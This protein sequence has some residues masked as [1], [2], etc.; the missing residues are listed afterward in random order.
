MDTL[1][2]V[3][4]QMPSL[5]L[6]VD[7]NIRNGG[8]PK[9]E[10]WPPSSDSFDEVLLP[11]EGT[12]QREITNIHPAVSFATGRSNKQWYA[13]LN[14]GA[15]FGYGAFGYGR[16]ALNDSVFEKPHAS[17]HTCVRLQVGDVLEVRVPGRTLAFHDEPWARVGWRAVMVERPTASSKPSGP[18]LN[19]SLGADE[20]FQ[21]AG[22][23]SLPASMYAL[24]PTTACSTETETAHGISTTRC[25]DAKGA[26]V[27]RRCWL[28][29]NRDG[30]PASKM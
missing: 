24:V 21:V 2:K 13:Q 6:R 4:S 5:S 3:D 30:A 22:Q 8:L 12:E 18:A 28:F 26:A 25:V 17:A 27:E 29:S 7:V 9:A 19:E 1:N 16:L 10:L 14:P 11:A 15:Y 23:L 20:L